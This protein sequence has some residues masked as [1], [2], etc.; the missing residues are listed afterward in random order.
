MK[1][2]IKNGLEKFYD[3]TTRS[4]LNRRMVGSG[5]A[6][7]LFGG[8]FLVGNGVINAVQ[9]NIA[10]A[11]RQQDIERVTK[12]PAKDYLD[13]YQVSIPARVP[14]GDAPTLTLCRKLGHGT[15][16]IDAVRT[17]IQFSDGKQTQVS[18]RNFNAAIE[19]SVT[20]TDCTAVPLQGQPQVVGEYQIVTEYC[21]KEPKYDI[22][23]C[24]NYRSN[25]YRMTDSL[26]QL[27][28]EIKRLQAEYDRR[29]NGGAV[30]PAPINTL[31]S[32]DGSTSAATPSASSSQQSTTPST[33][34]AGSNSNAGGSS[35]NNGQNQTTPQRSGL[36]IDLPLLPPIIIGG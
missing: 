15:I 4:Q 30:D 22:K 7:I 18:I 16:K 21:F 5:I 32:G 1:G 31:Q 13:F 19:E 17:F 2:I 12:A 25:K 8:I 3:F 34:A 27:N 6:L 28:E 24:D 29:L 11:E 23:K 20:N 10:R 14:L 26:N 9:E 33:P 36:I 35:S